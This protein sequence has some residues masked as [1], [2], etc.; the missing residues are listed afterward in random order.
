MKRS[1]GDAS[2]TVPESAFVSEQ[3]YIVGDV[4]LGDRAS[5]WPFVCLR[6]DGDGGSVSVGERTNVQ[7]FSTI[8]GATLGDGVTV[9]HGVTIDYATVAEDS[10]V[11]INS[12]VLQGATVESNCLVAAGSVVSPD[13]TIPAGHLAYGAPAETRPLTDEQHAEIERVRDHYVE[14]GRTYDAAGLGVNG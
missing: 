5:V 3:A 7:E 8:H 10:L 6:G 11:G 13:Q 12:V 2:P 14:L 4:A 1:I 9:G